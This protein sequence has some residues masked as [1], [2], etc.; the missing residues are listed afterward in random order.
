MSNITS[1]RGFIVALTLVAGIGLASC[2]SGDDGAADAPAD[3]SLE[4]TSDEVSVTNQW[5]RT[6]AM[7]TTMGAVYLDVTASA[8]DELVGVAVDES[9]AV[10]AELHETVTEG[11]H[12]MSGDT[13]M[14]D[15]GMKMQRIDKLDIPA[16]ETISLEP[17][18]YHIMLVDLV[19]PLETGTSFSLTLSFATAGDVTVEVPVLDEAP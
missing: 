14:P 12:S 4:M 10:A 19:A 8:G 5:A 3:S 7:A 6:S 13:T 15:G 17:G 16:G 9:V 11:G 2:G 1:T 18:G